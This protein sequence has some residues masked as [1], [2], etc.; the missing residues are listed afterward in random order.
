MFSSIQSAST[1]RSLLNIK[2]PFRCANEF[3]KYTLW[4]VHPTLGT[5]ALGDQ[6]ISLLPEFRSTGAYGLFAVFF[7]R[8]KLQLL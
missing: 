3:N 1:I 6:K 5:I 7:P 2:I 8:R 4:D